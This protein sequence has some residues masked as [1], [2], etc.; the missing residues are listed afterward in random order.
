MALRLFRSIVLTAIAASALPAAAAKPAA[1]FPVYPVPRSEQLRGGEVAIPRTVA[2]VTGPRSDSSAVRV[3]RAALTRAGV[4]RFEPGGHATFT[5]SLGVAKPAGVPAEG[6]VLTIG[7]GHIELDGADTA[8]TFYAAQSL[9]Q[10]VTEARPGRLPALAIRDWP[11][12]PVRGI[13]EGFY[14]TP[15][16]DRTRA[17]LLDFLAV[18]KMNT[19][20]Y[21]PKDDS[22]LRARWRD[23]YPAQRLAA[24]ARLAARARADHV[25]FVYALSPGPSICYSS[26]NDEKELVRKLQSVWDAG[27]R[28]FAIPFDDVDYPRWNCAADMTA[29][30]TGEAAAASAQVRVLNEVDTTFVATHRGAGRL[31]TVPTE[32]WGLNPSPYKDRLAAGLRPDVIVQWT[33]ST[34]YS[35]GI[36]R[37]GAAAAKRAYGH[38]VILWDNYPA[39]R[40]LSRL[41][42]APYVGREPGLRASVLGV[43]ANPMFEP[44]ASKIALFTVGDYAWNDAAY[45]PARSWAASLAELAGGDP[46]ATAA[47]EAFADANYASPSTPQQAPQLAALIGAFWQEFKAGSSGGAAATELAAA[48]R[49]LTAAPA[50]L[51]ARLHNSAFL[52]ETAPWLD[53]TRVWGQAMLASLDMLNALHDGRSADALADRQRV[54]ELVTLAHD[55]YFFG[56]GQSIPVEVGG[57]VFDTFVSAAL[58]EMDA[59]G[60]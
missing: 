49:E 60:R 48:L 9:R 5:V 53:A 45:D 43:T 44:E 20:L 37:E 51:Q 39:L 42:L 19:Y 8:G 57:G 21:S 50:T 38:D 11:A 17:E 27:I 4:R 40:R 25:L 46:V 55:Y 7:R 18:R 22:Y 29:F 56:N 59:A 2:L 54:L 52:H 12:L 47:L 15:W 6:Y 1:R 24:L 13:V 3:A 31:I 35:P 58:A 10:I 32:F 34:I 16:S 30:G 28:A 26:S 14:G 36:S 33:G 23:P 41:Q